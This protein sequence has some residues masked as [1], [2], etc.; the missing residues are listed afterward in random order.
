MEN[1][2]VFDYERI[3]FF[4]LLLTGF[5]EFRK[6]YDDFQKNG[7]LPR[8]VAVEDLCMKTFRDLRNRA[9]TIFRHMPETEEEASLHDIELLC[10]LVV[11]ACYHE[12]L[13]L[14]ENL[15][16]SKLYRPRY[17]DLKKQLLDASFQDCFQIGENLILEA[18]T[19]I[20]KNLRWTWKLL[21]E[22]L[23]LAKRYLAAHGKRR[24]ILR[25]IAQHV[26]LFEEAY[27]KEDLDE[28]YRDIFPGGLPEL[29]M[30]STEDLIQS[31]HYHAALD[32]ISQLAGVL[33]SAGNTDRFDT[34]QIVESL[35]KIC[36]EGKLLRD[37]RLVSRSQTLTSQIQDQ[38]A[39]SSG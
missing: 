21:V 17:E 32:R 4:H 31:A 7:N 19:Q 10:D 22:A 18:E 2:Q 11:G 36:A 1:S 5:I 14:Q 30:K 28:L 3:R 26:S 39:S 35:E 23:T 8:C 20:P 12:S 24:I 9:H 16:L 33:N 27:A 38:S 6:V 29:L 34:A 37:N 25:F 15:Y 13:Q